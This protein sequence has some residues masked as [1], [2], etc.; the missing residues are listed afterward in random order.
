LQHLQSGRRSG[1]SNKVILN[2]LIQF[3]LNNAANLYQLT[4]QTTT[5]CPTTWTYG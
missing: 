3:Y 5:S 1:A 4:S 2:L